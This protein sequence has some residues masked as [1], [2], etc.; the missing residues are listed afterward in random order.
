MAPPLVA[1]IARDDA[2][3][4][5]SAS[6]TSSSVPTATATQSTNPLYD[7][8]SGSRNPASFNNNIFL[9][10]FAVIG[11]CMALIC[12][13]FFTM[14]RHGGFHWKKTDW[15]DY[16]STVL[17]RKGPDGKTLSNATKSTKL[18]GGS[19][20]PKWA[21]DKSLHGSR[22]SIDEKSDVSRSHRSMKSDDP[23]FDAYRHEKPAGVGGLNKPAEGSHYD[24]T[25]TDPSTV[26]APNKKMTKKEKKEEA[27]KVKERQKQAKDRKQQAKYAPPPST[28]Q[29]ASTHETGSY[30]GVPQD[31]PSA[32][33]N[34]YYSNYRP[35]QT[36]RAVNED[37][38]PP[39]PQHQSYRNSADRG[40]PQR[41]SHR[42]HEGSAYTSGSGESGTKSYP[43]SIPGL[44][45]GEVGIYDSISQVGA[46]PPPSNRRNGTGG[47]RR[48]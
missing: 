30:F 44:T 22:S 43:H 11:A 33:R 45:K 26:S 29:S 10:L 12:L 27:K 23:E 34:S 8:G 19:I 4:F 16:K 6:S 15:D 21:A 7:P 9:I 31:S 48:G 1:L 32:Q 39:P 13:W 42:P 24:Y 28:V 5:I 36:V 17:R 46:N 38:P 3:S 35:G 18:G 20:V 37:T 40:S 14:S 47:Y 41:R 2:G 25:N